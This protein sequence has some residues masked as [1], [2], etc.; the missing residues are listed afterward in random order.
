MPSDAKKYCHDRS[1]REPRCDTS[2]RIGL[3]GQQCGFFVEVRVG[4]GAVS[5][6]STTSSGLHHRTW[7]VSYTL[8]VLESCFLRV[9][10]RTA[11]LAQILL[12]TRVSNEIQDLLQSSTTA[13]FSPEWPS[14]RRDWHK[15]CFRRPDTLSNEINDLLRF[16]SSTARHA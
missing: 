5:L 4:L 9:Q 3:T 7:S 10:L 11:R 13:H 6:R 12:Q 16:L 2:S 14:E 1:P 8:E 15:R